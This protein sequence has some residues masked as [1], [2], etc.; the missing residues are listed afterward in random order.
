[1]QPA[2]DPYT[3]TEAEIQEPPKSFWR[4]LRFLGPGFILSASI[5]GSG[6]LIAT[7]TLGARAGFT[8]FWLI[9]VSCVVKVTIQLEFGKHAISTGESTMRSFN[10]LPGPKFGRASW[11]IWVWLAMMLAK[12]VQLGGILG[13]VGVILEIAFPAL[14]REIW[15]SLA[16]VAVALLVFRGYYSLLEKVSLLLLALF[17]VLT[18]V[19]VGAL[20]WTEEYRVSWEQIASGLRFDL[21]A[22][23]VVVALGAFG[24]TGVGGDEIM[25]YNYWLIEKGYAR[26]TGPP[27][28]G[29]PQWVRRAR[30][31]IRVMYMDALASMVVYTVVTAAFYLLGAAILHRRG[32]V[33]EGFEMVRTLSRIYTETLGPWAETV[34]LAGAFVVLF[35]TLFSALGGWTRV[36]ADALGRIG[37]FDFD[38]PRQR[39]LAIA[40][41]AWLFP[42]IWAILIFIFKEPVGMVLVGGVITTAILLLVVFA[43]VFFRYRCLP[44]ELAPSRFYDLSFWMSVLA[45][46]GV[47]VIVLGS[48]VGWLGGRG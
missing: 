1:M 44:A 6:E 17:T 18:L 33:P 10:R 37:M 7:T 3:L 29:D 40:W 42:L 24:I 12:T 11:S 30:G 48:A 21:P 45:I 22:G 35:S 39:R 16:A 46:L 36:T 28:P 43:A 19:S 32:D 23:M 47:G 27:R 26:K 15:L 20:Q 9:L 41:L 13:G 34:F 31:W 5:V 14:R 4:S 25:H 38:N 2:G 8:A